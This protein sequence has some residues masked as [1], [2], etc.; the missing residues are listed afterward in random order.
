MFFW[1]L[2]YT[3]ILT[4]RA[5]LIG[6]TLFLHTFCEMGFLGMGSLN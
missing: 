2:F 5:E 6:I 1:A 4:G 3:S